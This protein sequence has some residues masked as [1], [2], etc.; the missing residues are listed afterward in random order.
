MDIHA[1]NGENERVGFVVLSANHHDDLD[2][3]ERLASRIDRVRR[4][5]TA[6]A[7]VQGAVVLSTCNRFEVYLDAE[8][9]SIEP[10]RRIVLGS[11]EHVALNTFMGLDAAR[12]VYEVATG[13]DS[14]VVGEREIVGQVRGALTTARREGT[15]SPLLEQTLQG[16]LRTSRA[17]AVQTDISHAGRSIVAVALDL[18]G[19]AAC[20][21]TL[22]SWDETGGPT[23]PATDWSG[24]RVLL[25]GTGAYAGASVAALAERGADNVRVWSKSGRGEQFAADHGIDF[26]PHLDL[27]WPDV[28][29]L[30]RGTGS[31]VLTEE[32]VA[33][34][35][36]G[37]GPLT[38]IDLALSRDVEK[39]AGDMDNVTLIDLDIVRR[40]VP[41]A[42]RG[43]V[44]RAHAIIAEGLTKLDAELLGRTMDPLV[45]SIRNMFAMALEKEL[46]RLPAAGEIPAEDAV[47]ALQRLTASIAY[48]PTAA[49]Q[50]AAKNGRGKEYH[51][52][53]QVFLGLEL[54][55]PKRDIFDAAE[56]CSYL[57][58]HHCV[59]SGTRAP[60]CPRLENHHHA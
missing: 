28:I 48:H 38:L 2:D 4:D 29:V 53:A 47:R 14:M 12:H 13:L 55:Q 1:K 23:V 41:A 27:A 39:S 57:A 34:A 52:A 51:E 36:A 54:P 40:H 42:A 33:E 20:E 45:V 35:M 24:I 46:H 7:G 8:E 37:R 10:V 9:A 56:P 18:A 15:T 49:A 43:D 25:V 30:C 22:Y 58:E 50:R 32:M 31:P 17:V 59:C 5:I 60:S 21:R 19:N 6:T 26:S 16:A 44:E 3:V 11:D